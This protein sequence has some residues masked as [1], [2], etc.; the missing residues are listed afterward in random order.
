VDELPELSKS[1]WRKI[2]KNMAKAQ[3]KEIA[4]K[5]R[6][7]TPILARDDDPPD[8]SDPP[9]VKRRRVE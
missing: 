1:D 5:L 3:L 7:I 6:E 9:P 8:P 2:E 4:E